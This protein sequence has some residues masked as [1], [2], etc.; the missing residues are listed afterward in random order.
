M[1]NWD[2]WLTFPLTRIVDP[3]QAWAVLKGSASQYFNGEEEPLLKI[4]SKKVFKTLVVELSH[5]R[6][7]KR[8]T[9]LWTKR[10]VSFVVCLFQWG[11]EGVFPKDTELSTKVG[12]ICSQ[13]SDYRGSEPENALSDMNGTQPRRWLVRKTGSAIQRA[14][15]P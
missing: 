2:L 13:G 3:K 9:T 1:L 5:I 4:S 15:T 12:Q 6:L 7:R 11:K 8:D 14:P 10:S